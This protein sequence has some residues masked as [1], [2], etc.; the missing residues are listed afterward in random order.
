M[1]TLNETV[2]V[3]IKASEFYMQTLFACLRC[4]ASVNAFQNMLLLTH[5][6]TNA[7]HTKKPK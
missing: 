7:D 5:Q 1:I 3:N 4:T 2:N 6:H